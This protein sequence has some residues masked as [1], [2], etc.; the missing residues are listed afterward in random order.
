MTRT[1]VKW[2]DDRVVDGKGAGLAHICVS[3]LR[4]NGQDAHVYDS[5]APHPFAVQAMLE[6]GEELRDLV[7]LAESTEDDLIVDLD[8]FDLD[9]PLEDYEDLYNEER[10][11]RFRSARERIAQLV[12]IGEII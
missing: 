10:I 12:S 8:D 1:L 5:L 9:N 6:V 2:C 3:F 4:A 7:V 11:H